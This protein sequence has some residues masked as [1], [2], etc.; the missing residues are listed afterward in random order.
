MK[1]WNTYQGELGKKRALLKEKHGTETITTG[2]KM[3]TTV[4]ELVGDLPEY[5]DTLG[6][7][8]VNPEK[9]DKNPTTIIGGFGF[10]A[11]NDKSMDIV[12]VGKTTL[13]HHQEF[14]TDAFTIHT[15]YFDTCRN[16]MVILQPK[17]KL[18]GGVTGIVD[19][20]AL[21]NKL[22]LV[23][24]ELNISG[25][26]SLSTPYIQESSS[27][28][29][30]VDVDTKTEGETREA[31]DTITRPGEDKVSEKPFSDVTYYDRP[32]TQRWVEQKILEARTHGESES[33]QDNVD[34]H[35]TQDN[36]S[37][38]DEDDIDKSVPIF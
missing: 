10:I 31:T 18:E 28:F 37:I 2:E 5:G 7:W 14:E 27:Q 16:P 32:D 8:F 3:M 35:S 17:R 4:R 12:G 20:V 1:D 24:Q 23:L 34:G 11:N 25:G 33:T 21:Q 15:G 6:E 9:T 38:I 26:F 36:A 13:Y 30:V 19:Q 22:A 29:E